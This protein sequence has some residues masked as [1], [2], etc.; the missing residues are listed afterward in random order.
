MI[1]R[2]LLLVGL[3]AASG[4][5][6]AF[7]ATPPLRRDYTGPSVVGHENQVFN[8]F[9][10]TTPMPAEGYPVVVSFDAGGFLTAS[11]PTTVT[12]AT[13]FLHDVLTSGVAVVWASGTPSRGGATGNPVDG[14]PGDG[15]GPAYPGNGVFVP[16]GYEM[17]PG[18]PLHPIHDTTRPMCEKDV[19]M[20]VQHVKHEAAS[21]GVD[22]ERVALFARSAGAISAWFVAAGPD[23][24]DVWLTPAG[25]E[26]ED[27]SLSAA[28]VRSGAAY[29]PAFA[30]EHPPAGYH[31]PRAAG[32]TF[33]Q[34]AL[35]LGDV[36]LALLDAASALTWALDEVAA[37]GITLDVHRRPI[38]MTYGGTTLTAPDVTGPPYVQ[39]HYTNI[40]SAWSGFAMKDAFCN[41]RLVLTNATSAVGMP[42]VYDALYEADP[43]AVDADMLGWLLDVWQRG[44]VDDPWSYAELGSVGHGGVVPVLRGCGPFAAATDNTVELRHAA[45][46]ATSTL[47]AGFAELLAPFKGGLLAPT[48]DLLVTLTVDASGAWRL[49]IALPPDTPAG[50]SLVMQA[51]VLDAQAVGGFAS[52]NAA[53]VE[54]S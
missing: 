44:G 3:A 19:V 26:L 50:L 1:A 49:P 20:L 30:T 8:V 18:W 27:T 45:P 7:D 17:P 12:A 11:V 6:Q 47:V 14:V 4:A 33:D 22:P 43:D 23:R 40:H 52:S 41:A 16:P 35:G 32:G 13:G 29:W 46:G 25:Q 38:H 39:D 34:P 37:P 10:P 21:L 36:D 2:A 42:E 53:S 9:Y 48:P 54:T 24:R 31:L 5:G 28:L 51:W 15:L